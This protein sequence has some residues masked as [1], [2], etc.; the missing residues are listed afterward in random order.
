MKTKQNTSLSITLTFLGTGLCSLGVSFL[1]LYISEIIFTT[2]SEAV[3]KLIQMWHL[4]ICVLSI[5]F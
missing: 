2:S 5:G 1:F 4:S 3:K